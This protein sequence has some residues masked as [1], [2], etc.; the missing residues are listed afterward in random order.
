MNLTN[1]CGNIKRPYV[2]KLIMKRKA[3]EKEPA[4]PNVQRCFKAASAK[5]VS[6][7]LKHRHRLAN[8]VRKLCNWLMA[9]CTLA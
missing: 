9:N 3:K 5:I 2:P 8:N 6:M 1:L 7:A 4:I